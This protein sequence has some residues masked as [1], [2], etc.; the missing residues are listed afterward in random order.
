MN[1]Q[2]IRTARLIGEAA[3]ERLERSNVCVVGVGGV[4]SF[5]AEAIC[6]AGVGRITLIDGDTVAESNLNRQLIALRS[7]PGRPKAE[8]VK[9]RME[10]INPQAQVT[11]LNFFYGEDTGP[12]L[13]P[14]DYVI[15]AIDSVDAKVLLV[16]R[17]QAAGV[18]VISCMGTGNKLDPSRFEIADINQTSVCPLAR[19]MRRRLREKGISHLTVLY[20]R[21]EPV[22]PDAPDEN[23]R[24]APASISFVPSVA[25]LMIAGHVIRA[26]AGI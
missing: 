19:V 9:A 14:F 15:D 25:G 8:V 13:A 2:H 24:R 12:D 10:D 1:G 20:S 18:P 4:G 16:Q 5:A 23:G 22:A 11:A 26:L 3:L 17:C 7:T 6:R 21:E